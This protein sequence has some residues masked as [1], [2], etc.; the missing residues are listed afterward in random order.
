VLKS[1][2]LISTAL[3]MLMANISDYCV[4]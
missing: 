3:L 1:G 2:G 4:A